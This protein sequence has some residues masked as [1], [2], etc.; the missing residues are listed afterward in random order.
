M[1]PMY[2]VNLVLCIIILVLGYWGFRKNKDSVPLYIGV[3]FGLFGLS[4][5]SILLG[6]KETL[7]VALIVVRLLAYLIVIFALYKVVK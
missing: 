6:L 5:L 3:A 4:H 1:D 7:G 2:A